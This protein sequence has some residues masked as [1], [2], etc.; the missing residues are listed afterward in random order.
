M[1]FAFSTSYCHSAPRW[2]TSWLPLKGLSLV[3]IS[4]VRLKLA[5][6]CVRPTSTLLTLSS[7]TRAKSSL[8]FSAAPTTSV[9]IC[10]LLVDNIVEVLHATGDMS[11]QVYAMQVARSAGDKW[12]FAAEC[13]PC[14]GRRPEWGALLPPPPQSRGHQTLN[15]WHR[16]TSAFTAEGVALTEKD[17]HKRRAIVGGIS[18][19]NVLHGV[20]YSQAHGNVFFL[21]ISG[22]NSLDKSVPSLRGTDPGPDH[23]S[24]HQSHHTASVWPLERRAFRLSAEAL[25]SAAMG[26]LR[27]RCASTACCGSSQSLTRLL[28]PRQS[29]PK[30]SVA[31]HLSSIR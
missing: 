28:V 21:K 1:I 2:Q 18:K 15:A 23:Q 30:P 7:I 17:S 20:L 10:Y 4:K 5:W 11:R 8:L 13:R 24:H 29:D 31:N 6:S 14:R 3:S 22:N 12:G 27:L 9:L 19:V 25:P 26:K 16:A